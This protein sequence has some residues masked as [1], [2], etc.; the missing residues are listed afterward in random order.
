MYNI[1][2]EIKIVISLENKQIMLKKILKSQILRDVLFMLCL[3]IN[4]Y[5]FLF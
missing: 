1:V 2:H 4:K 3:Y 5:I